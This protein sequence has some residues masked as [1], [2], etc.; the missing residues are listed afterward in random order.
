[1]RDGEGIFVLAVVICA[2][3][4]EALSARLAMI[5]TALRP[6]TSTPP[7]VIRLGL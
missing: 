5:G 1:M 7:A 6:I 2:T 3:R 4:D